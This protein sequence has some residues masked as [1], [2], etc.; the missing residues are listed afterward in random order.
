MFY[1]VKSKDET[2]K[3]Y[4]LYSSMIDSDI[5]FLNVYQRPVEKFSNQSPKLINFITSKKKM[6]LIKKKYKNK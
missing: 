5:L 3:L 6:Y 1:I 2:I 4:T